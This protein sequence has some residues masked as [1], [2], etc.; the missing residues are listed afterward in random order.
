MGKE[1]KYATT[2]PADK[3]IW[4]ACNRCNRDTCHKVL[5]SVA[6]RD[7]IP[8]VP[9]SYAEDYETLIC[10]GCKSVTFRIESSNSEDMEQDDEGNIVESISEQLYPPRIAGRAELEDAHILPHNVNQIYHQTR[11]ALCNKLH[12]LSGIGIRAI[13]E[14]VCTE[15]SAPGGDLK[16]QIQSL[17]AMGLTTNDGANILHSLRF[18][19]N[20]AAH[21][22]KAHT[23]RELFIAF[24]VIE[25]LLKGVYI[26]PKHA[27]TLPKAP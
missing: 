15:K 5:A 24:D 17:V 18:M 2:A 4:I 16:A 26:L 3:E 25:H 27:A 23:E 13:V 22:V 11:I 20:K 9:I 14:A 21:E 19:G 12:I 6:T 8:Q 10:L 7:E 1:F